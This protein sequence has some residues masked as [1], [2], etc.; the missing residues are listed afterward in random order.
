MKF[1]T[2]VKAINSLVIV[3]VVLCVSGLIVGDS[4]A[5]M[6]LVLTAA[7]L[8]LLITA[9]I[10]SLTFCRC[11]YCGK[12]IF[13]GAARVEYCPNCRRNLVTGKKGSRKRVTR[14]NYK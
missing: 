4:N 7:A 11:P 8:L 1:K 5:A 13:F 6:R 10:I 14:A 3:S 2:A 12:R 9:L